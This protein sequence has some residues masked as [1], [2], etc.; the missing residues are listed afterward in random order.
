[1]F[2]IFIKTEV[3]VAIK[4]KYLEALFSQITDAAYLNID[5]LASAFQDSAESSFTKTYDEMTR[6]TKPSTK[7]L[8]EL[9]LV[10]LEI[11]QKQ[12]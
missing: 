8:I 2:L 12:F 4:K 5:T 9:A 3:P 1:M 11:G 7:V 10:N 6:I